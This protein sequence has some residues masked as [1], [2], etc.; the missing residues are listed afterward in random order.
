[1]DQMVIKSLEEL[2]SKFGKGFEIVVRMKNGKYKEF[3]KVLLSKA[4]HSSSEQA[5]K[6]LCKDGMKL[7]K[8][9]KKMNKAINIIKRLEVFDSVMGMMNLCATTAGFIIVCQKL[10]AI[11][12]QVQDVM[13]ATKEMYHQE[14]I[15]KFDKIV[16]DH[17]EMLDG[18][19]GGMVFTEE[20]YLELIKEEN[21]LLKLLYKIFCDET[22]SNRLEILEAI[23]ALSAMMSVAI[24]DFDTIY[25]YKHKEKKSL[26]TGHEAWID[27]YNNLLSSEFVK[28][29]QD[30]FFIDED[31]TQYETDI[32]VEGVEEKFELAKEAISLK[33]EFLR[34]LNSKE[35]YD[36][37][38]EV[39]NDSISNDISDLVKSEEYQS[40]EQLLALCKETQQSVGLYS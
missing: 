27:T 34:M 13:N 28:G 20:K 38:I 5:I 26:Y 17:T 39:I 21:T 9:T 8:S 22:S 25:R 18:K 12:N 40:D 14:T 6:K 36:K 16:E 3:T 31:R 2:Q 30:F 19:D 15:Y 33:V 23:L 29:L 10:N 4:K 32:L 24:C 37:A 1:M 11:S 7:L 35:E